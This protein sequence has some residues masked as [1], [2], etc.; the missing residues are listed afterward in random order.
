MHGSN[1]AAGG[2]SNFSQTYR[3]RRREAHTQVYSKP[4]DHPLSVVSLTIHT[5]FVAYHIFE[6][7]RRNKKEGMRSKKGMTTFWSYC[8]QDH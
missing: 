2:G 4:T 5:S 6:Y 3:E 7:C 8:L 1:T